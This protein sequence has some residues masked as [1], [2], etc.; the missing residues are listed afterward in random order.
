[1][2]KQNK[3]SKLQWRF[4]E[5]RHFTNW[6]YIYNSSNFGGANYFIWSIKALFTAHS[7]KVCGKREFSGTKAVCVYNSF[8]FY[9]VF[10]CLFVVLFA[11]YNLTT[12]QKA[13]GES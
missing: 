1:M 13:L 3:S 11:I 12:V 8:L 7:L 2:Q 9:D 10:V 6:T 5:S 4:M